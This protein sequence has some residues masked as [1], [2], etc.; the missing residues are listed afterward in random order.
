MMRIYQVI[1]IKEKERDYKC[2]QVY[3]RD[4]VAAVD[5]QIQAVALL[6][7]QKRAATHLNCKLRAHFLRKEG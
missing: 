6:T 7:G 3:N 5:I 2:Y 1:E 4:K